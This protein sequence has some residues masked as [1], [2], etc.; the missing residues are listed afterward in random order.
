MSHYFNKAR[1]AHALYSTVDK[2]T[3]ELESGLTRKKKLTVQLFSYFLHRH[4]LKLSSKN[5]LYTWKHVKNTNKNHGI[6]ILKTMSRFGYIKYTPRIVHADRHLSLKFA[7]WHLFLVLTGSRS[8]V[9]KYFMYPNR[10][11]VFHFIFFF[12]PTW[13][14]KYFFLSNK[15]EHY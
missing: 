7:Y 10:D 13:T 4:A 8:K 12:P 11:I 9:T 6:S 15:P 3:D 2:S 1:R 5:V 14:W